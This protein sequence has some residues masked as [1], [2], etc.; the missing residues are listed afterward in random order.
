MHIRESEHKIKPLHQNSTKSINKFF[1]IKDQ[2]LY[3]FRFVVSKR[4][5]GKKEGNKEGMEKEKEE[6]GQR[7]ERG[8]RRKEATGNKNH[9]IPSTILSNT[10]NI[11][12]APAP[13][14]TQ[15]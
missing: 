14:P 10:F 15:R 6:G 9:P 13:P 7:E 11:R 3:A 2:I 5:E 12:D 4:K 1:T 8:G